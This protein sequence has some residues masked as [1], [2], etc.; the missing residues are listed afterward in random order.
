MN[1][2]NVPSQSMFRTNVESFGY[3]PPPVLKMQRVSVGNTGF[4]G[5]ATMSMVQEAEDPGM[6]ARLKIKGLIKVE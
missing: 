2:R 3:Q 1:E 6:H 4:K 5:S